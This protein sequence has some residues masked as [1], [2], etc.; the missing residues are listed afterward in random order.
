MPTKDAIVAEPDLRLP[1]DLE[2][3]PHAITD[4]PARGEVNQAQNERDSLLGR[5]SKEL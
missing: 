4:T 5:H 2:R 3:L 1:V